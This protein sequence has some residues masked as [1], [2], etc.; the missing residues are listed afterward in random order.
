MLKDY[1]VRTAKVPKPSIKN[2]TYFQKAT[3]RQVS[4]RKYLAVVT[5][6]A[7]FTYVIGVNTSTHSL[8]AVVTALTNQ[9]ILLDLQI[10]LRGITSVSIPTFVDLSAMSGISKPSARPTYISSVSSSS[11][12]TGYLHVA[13]VRSCI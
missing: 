4:S 7:S 2:I 11:S 9:D 13:Q 12:G 10:V 5:Y 8:I 3:S 1:V 6:P